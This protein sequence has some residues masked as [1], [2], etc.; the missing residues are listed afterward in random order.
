M[1]RMVRRTVRVFIQ[2]RAPLKSGRAGRMRVP[3]NVSVIGAGAWG[4]AGVST[5]M[6]VAGEAGQAYQPDRGVGAG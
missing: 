5:R 2:A 6:R 4:V 3:M 1:L